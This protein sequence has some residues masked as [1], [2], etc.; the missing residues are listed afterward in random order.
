M[1]RRL[2]PTTNQV[3]PSGSN[4]TA[5]R[6]RKPGTRSA[7]PASSLTSSLI[8]CDNNGVV[9]SLARTLVSCHDAL[10]SG[11]RNADLRWRYNAL[12]SGCTVAT[13]VKVLERIR[14]ELVRADQGKSIQRQLHGK[15]MRCHQGALTASEKDVGRRDAA[16][17]VTTAEVYPLSKGISK[18]GE[19]CSNMSSMMV[20]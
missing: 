10:N 12:F 18:G 8:P 4:R 9:K 1:C 19:I 5:D 7:I 17:C 16:V 13:A 15:S 14:V 2:I 3:S 11:E 6:R 20:Q